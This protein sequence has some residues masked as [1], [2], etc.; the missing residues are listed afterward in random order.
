MVT[1]TQNLLIPVLSSS[2]RSRHRGM[3]FLEEDLPFCGREFHYRRFCRQKTTLRL[4]RL[5]LMVCPA[6]RKTSDST[7][8]RLSVL[9]LCLGTGEAAYAC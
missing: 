1:R 2:S 3:S 5:F 9:P 6:R 7:A 4:N 8:Q